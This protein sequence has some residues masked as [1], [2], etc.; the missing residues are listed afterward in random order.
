MTR[1]HSVDFPM[2]DTRTATSKIPG[3]FLSTDDAWP[4]RA[5]AYKCS[6]MSPTG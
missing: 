1:N 3:E 6:P 2:N 4:L 5:V